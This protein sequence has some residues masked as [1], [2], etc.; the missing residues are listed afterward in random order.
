MPYSN[1]VQNNDALWGPHATLAEL[2]IARA[3]DGTLRALGCEEAIASHESNLDCNSW[4]LLEQ[5]IAS[6]TSSYSSSSKSL[7]MVPHCWHDG[8]P[9]VSENEGTAGE[10]FYLPVAHDDIRDYFWVFG[11]FCSL[12]CAAKFAMERVHLNGKQIYMLIQIMAVKL[13]GMTHAEATAPG[14]PLTP[15]ACR[16]SLRYFGNFGPVGM[17]IKQ[18]RSRDGSCRGSTCYRK[19]PFLTTDNVNNHHHY[20]LH[21][22]TEAAAAAA[23]ANATGGTA[24]GYEHILLYK[25]FS[26]KAPY[27]MISEYVGWRVP[28]N[29]F[30]NTQTPH[31]RAS[32]NDTVQKTTEL[33]TCWHDMHEI[34]ADIL[35]VGIPISIE[36]EDGAALTYNMF[37]YFCSGNCALAYV[38]EMRDWNSGDQAVYVHRFCHE[39]LGVP[40]DEIIEPAEPVYELDRF[41]GPYSIREYRELFCSSAMVRIS[42]IDKKSDSSVASHPKHLAKWVNTAI[43][44]QTF[45][46]PSRYASLRSLGVMGSSSSSSN[47]SS[48]SSSSILSSGEKVLNQR[49]PP[50]SSS[51]SPRLKQNNTPA[52]P[53]HFLQKLM[54]IY[55]GVLPEEITP[56]IEQVVE[57]KVASKDGVSKKDRNKRK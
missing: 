52:P 14:G 50:S 43:E 27:V 5:R 31:S 19:P 44:Y 7:T 12:S 29:A 54:Q 48:S 53:S 37:G 25:A 24:A 2:I 36:V 49:R 18:F 51:S 33:V 46:L 55:N 56:Q 57:D 3:D 23:A 47:N 10:I 38:Q 41:G 42:S 15:A 13:Y 26:E 22:P 17:S 32:N 45:V 1:H 4:A 30:F 35:P 8:H 39:V 16:Q 6:S 20:N 11:R 34:P 28:E 9:I 40:Y 21:S